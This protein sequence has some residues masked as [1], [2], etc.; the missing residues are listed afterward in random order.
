MLCDIK[1]GK[2]LGQQ[3]TTNGGKG[4]E[5]KARGAENLAVG[6][7]SWLNKR[8]DGKEGIVLGSDGSFSPER[9]PVEPWHSNGGVHR[10]SGRCL[11]EKKPVNYVDL[12]A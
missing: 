4:S 6:R 8:K 5:R 1:D 2:L 10:T 11:E 7:F 3:K 9:G 12:D